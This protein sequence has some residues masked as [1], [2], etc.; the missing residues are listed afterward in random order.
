MDDLRE[1]V[2]AVERAI[3]DGDGDLTALAE[4]AASAERIDA[5]ETTVDALQDDVA[6]L[7]AA[8]Q[9]LRGYVGSIRSVNE[10]VEERA[11]A[12]IAAVDALEDRLPSEPRS[13]DVDPNPVTGEDDTPTG[14]Q[15]ASRQ[16]VPN[17]TEDRSEPAQCR[18]CG[19]AVD[20]TAA[21]D[22]GRVPTG[23]P[24][25]Q[26][27]TDGGVSTPLDDRSATATTRPHADL[28]G[29]DPDAA[30]SRVAV[31]RDFTQSTDGGDTARRD[32]ESPTPTLVERLREWL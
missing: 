30:G 13:L 25:H 3:T 17:G 27:N 1:R 29:F 16:S 14:S 20:E 12:A 6:E 23:P 15:D 2:E 4:G 8:T 26:S 31:R 24:T 7:E 10:S 11:D 5:L 22:G 32:A 28:D 9:A 18:A 19:R 21:A